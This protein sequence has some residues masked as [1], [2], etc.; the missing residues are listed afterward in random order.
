MQRHPPCSR[1]V[2]R[3]WWVTII[4]TPKVR[5][6]TKA[7]LFDSFYASRHNETVNYVADCADRPVCPFLKLINKHIR[8]TGGGVRWRKHVPFHLKKNCHK[9]HNDPITTGL[10]VLCSNRDFKKDQ[11]H[12][13]WCYN[14]VILSFLTF[15]KHLAPNNKKKKLTLFLESKLSRLKTM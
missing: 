3:H 13:M 5:K 1:E 15:L 2:F 6:M 10:T 4:K 12:N 14:Q 11:Y 7:T 8:E 9:L